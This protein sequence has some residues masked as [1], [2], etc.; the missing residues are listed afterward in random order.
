MKHSFTVAKIENLTLV[1]K[2]GLKNAICFKLVLITFISKSNIWIKSK[3]AKK[4]KLMNLVEIIR[5]LKIIAFG[6]SSF[7]HQLFGVL[8]LT[9]HFHSCFHGL[10]LA[11]DL[12]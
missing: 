12:S 9:S 6:V 3:N 4:K 7:L 5:C 2:H 1:G 8:K 10:F 11:S